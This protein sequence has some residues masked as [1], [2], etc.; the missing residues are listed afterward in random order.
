M[1]NHHVKWVNKLEIAILK[2]Y[3]ER[4]PEARFTQ[5]RLLTYGCHSPEISV[6]LHAAGVQGIQHQHEGL[7]GGW[8]MLGWWSRVDL[9]GWF[10]PL[11]VG[12][13]FYNVLLRWE[14]SPDLENTLWWCQQL[15]IDD[16]HRNS[17][18]SHQRWWI[19]PYLCKR[20]PEGNSYDKSVVDRCGLKFWHH[21]LHR[22][23][24]QVEAQTFDVA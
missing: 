8:D 20:L 17:G 13:F 3:F 7:P 18:I 15:A 16:G 24:A 5:G 21:S 1:E 9:A 23:D 19:V 4:L 6:I 2:S 12:G 10:P 22:V 14:V 11:L